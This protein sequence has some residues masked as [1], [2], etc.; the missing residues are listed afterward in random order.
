MLY[1]LP[2]EQILSP[3]MILGAYRGGGGADI[4]IIDDIRCLWGR[5]WSRLLPLMILGACGG[6]VEQ[7]PLM[8]LGACGGGGGA[9]PLSLI[10]SGFMVSKLLS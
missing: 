2:H 9:L 5:G 1:P 8:T 6:G 4:V 7:L 10:E 3:L